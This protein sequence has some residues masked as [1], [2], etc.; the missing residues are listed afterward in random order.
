[1]ARLYPSNIDVQLTAEAGDSAEAAIAARLKEDLDDAYT[2]FWELPVAWREPDGLREA[3]IDLAVVNREG[4]CLLIELKQGGIEETNGALVK[5]YASGAKSIP[6]QMQRARDGLRNAFAKAH[7]K[8]KLIVSS[9][10]LCPDHMVKNPKAAGLDPQCIV[11]ASRAA[12]L[13]KAIAEV[14]PPGLDTRGARQHHGR[15]C[16]F[17]AG[18]FR[19]V[20]DVTSGLQA[21]EDR[22]LRLA[23]SALE[24]VHRLDMAP[25]WRVRI[26]GVPGCGKTIALTQTWRRWTTAGQRVLMVCFNR[27]LRERLVAD[28]APELAQGRIETLFGLLDKALGDVSGQRLQG[29]P[30]ASHWDGLREALLGVDLP[31]AW[32][33]DALIVDEGQDLGQRD[34]EHLRLFLTNDAPILWVEDPQQT[35]QKIDPLD[36]R[37]A[38]FVTLKT[39]ESFR[40]PASIAGF[41][42]RLL[43]AGL[44]PRNP[45]PGE[46]VD[47]VTLAP[48]TPLESLLADRIDRLIATGYARGDIVILSLAGQDSSALSSV[49]RVG[50]HRLIRFTGEYQDDQQVMTH[51]DIRFETVRRFKGLQAPAVIVIDAN[52]KEGAWPLAPWERSLWLIA[53]TRALRRLEIVLPATSQ[54]LSTVQDCL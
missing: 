7:P 38:G 53:A 35:V 20:Q 46:P 29:P 43:G 47:L 3:E 27:L 5:R 45:V 32:Q 42:N 54:R 23:P 31:A 12:Q 16:Q 49:E 11:D 19:L 48:E 44:E 40:V 50:K 26:D 6:Q 51:G 17:L 39:R 25:P 28:L 22:F 1:M 10:L 24:A 2:V 21:A 9:L 30:D 52:G 15:V 8:D 41:V 14:L 4:R 37:D 34:F 36:W 13:P 18:Q 33:F